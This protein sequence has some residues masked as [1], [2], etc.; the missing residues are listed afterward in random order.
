MTAMVA[1]PCGFLG[2][3]GLLL[4]LGV[5][6]GGADK[7]VP[8]K[9]VVMMNG[10][11]ISGAAVQFVVIGTGGRP[12]SAETKEDGSYQMTTNT[13]GDGALP[14]EY[15]VLISWEPP[16]PPVFRSG[17]EGPSRQDMQRALDQHQAKLKKAGKGVTVP[18][19]YSDPGK[20]PLTVKVPAPGG[21]ADFTLSNKP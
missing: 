19:I 20:T 4:G 18:A 16:P 3:A 12:A 14:G 11:P 10:Q 6:C 21:R 15:R 17:E 1:R 7:P 2:L 5:G 8:V 13:P 9:G